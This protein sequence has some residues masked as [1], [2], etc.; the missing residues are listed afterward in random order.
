LKLFVE[1]KKPRAKGLAAELR[2]LNSGWMAIIQQH[3]VGTKL[4]ALNVGDNFINT[5]L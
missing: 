5:S 3:T 2:N 1:R 4:K